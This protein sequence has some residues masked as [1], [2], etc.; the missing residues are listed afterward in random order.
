MAAASSLAHFN[1]GDAMDR[2]LETIEID[3]QYAE[4]LGFAL[5]DV[6]GIGLTRVLVRVF[7]N[8]AGRSRLVCYMTLRMPRRW[9]R[10]LLLLMIGKFW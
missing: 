9:P 2:A 4:G 5:D 8:V 7:L 10:N 6:V 1:S 3:P